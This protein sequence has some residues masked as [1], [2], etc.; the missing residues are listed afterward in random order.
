M[1]SDLG[2]FYSAGF[3]VSS[4]PGLFLQMSPGVWMIDAEK[5][6]VQRFV[7]RT[8]AP[9]IDSQAEEMRVQKRLV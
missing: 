8:L 1:S 9:V 7:E 3:S 4:R 2:L 6:P 5:P